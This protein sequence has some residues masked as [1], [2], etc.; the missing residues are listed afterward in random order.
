LELE[1][2]VLAQVPALALPQVPVLPQVLALPRV[3][4][5]PQVLALVLPPLSAARLLLSSSCIHR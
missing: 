4:V 5:L 2:K 1:L 3:P